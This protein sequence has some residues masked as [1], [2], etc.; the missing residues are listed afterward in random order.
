MKYE[1]WHSC[2]ISALELIC[3]C[4]IVSGTYLVITSGVPVSVF[5]FGLVCTAKRVLYV[6][7]NSGGVGHICAMSQAIF[8]QRHMPIMWNVYQCSWSQ[9]WLHWVL[10]RCIYWC[11]CLICAHELIGTW[12]LLKINKCS[13]AVDN[14]INVTWW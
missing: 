4:G 10:I 7:H 1:D 2:L 12:G 3:T 13:G 14:A 6:D 8:V 9:C 11:S 5:Y